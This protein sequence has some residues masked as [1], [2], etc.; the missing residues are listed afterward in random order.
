MV[1]GKHHQ[2]STF[3]PPDHLVDEVSRRV[4]SLAVSY[5]THPGPFLIGVDPG[6]SLPHPPPIAPNTGNIGLVGRGGRA[7]ATV[8]NRSQERPL[9]TKTY[10][11]NA[12]NSRSR[13]SNRPQAMG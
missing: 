12:A 1:E 7:G 6:A 4:H 9:L 5:S 10:E 8:P 13:D 11:N 2:L 3:L